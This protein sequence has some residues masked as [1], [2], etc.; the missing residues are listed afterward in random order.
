MF[1]RI[2]FY[3]DGHWTVLTIMIALIPVLNFINK[4]LSQDDTRYHDL[5]KV[6]QYEIKPSLRNA[7]AQIS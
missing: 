6:K 2:K 7:K 3:E 4:K 5:L 1:R